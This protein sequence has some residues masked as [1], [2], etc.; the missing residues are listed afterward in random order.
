MLNMLGP[1]SVIV[2]LAGGL[3][4]Q[5][6]Q[7]AAGLELAT[8]LG[9]ELWI[10]TRALDE[11]RRHPGITPREYELSQ[12][13][14]TASIA[15]SAVLQHLGLDGR[16]LPERVGSARWVASRVRG[17]GRR[18]RSLE[19][20]HIIRERSLA[21]SDQLESVS[22]LDDRSHYLIGYWQS[23]RYFTGVESEI[24]AQC[25]LSSSL[26]SGL[27]EVARLIEDS[28]SLCVHVRRGDL[29]QNR[30][31]RQFH[32]L[33]GLDYYRGAAGRLLSSGSF[34]SIFVFSD[35]V[36]WCREHLSWD[37]PVT[38]VGHEEFG[39][40]SAE[41][42]VTMS[43]AGGYVVA[44]S[45][46][47]WWAAWLSGVDGSRIVAPQHWTAQPGSHFDALIPSGWTRL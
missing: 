40:T 35:D 8:R 23:P 17:L 43:R 15:D 26:P 38:Y 25:A 14:L 31:A 5:L 37:L 47:S 42:L 20:A 34:D 39:G 7:Y 6:F 1:R 16:V 32:G 10:D 29:V 46:F 27:A 45:T 41:H 13:R 11:L 2:Q 3:G 12:F 4:N 22:S 30:S 36:A 18:P 33:L 28:R 19:T 9:S 21:Y 24:R 44:N